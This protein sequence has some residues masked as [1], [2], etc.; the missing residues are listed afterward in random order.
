MT[1]DFPDYS[2]DKIGLGGGCHWCTEAVF[3]ALNGVF[4]VDQ[5]YLSSQGEYSSFSE[6]VVVYYKKEQI[7]LDVLIKI[8]LLTHQSSAAH[9]LRKKYRS[10]IYT[11][12]ESQFYTVKKMLEDLKK[13]FKRDI[14]TEV[15]PLRDFRSS[16]PEV[17]NYYL[18]D[19]ERPF[20]SRYIYDKIKMIKEEFPLYFNAGFPL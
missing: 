20:C 9:R 5:G 17:L 18:S 6:G 2:T 11:V 7:G 1:S 3:Q 10:A 14:V 12:S 13:E 15:I 16:P 19:P 8:H 4:R